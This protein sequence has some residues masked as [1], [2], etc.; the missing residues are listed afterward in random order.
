MFRR[1]LFIV[2]LASC[3]F[4]QAMAQKPVPNQ[5]SLKYREFEK[6]SQK[7]KFTRFL[8]KLIFKPLVAKKPVRLTK[9]K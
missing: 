1:L 5:D 2:L 7:T 4:G 9:K 3:F 6:F 8:H